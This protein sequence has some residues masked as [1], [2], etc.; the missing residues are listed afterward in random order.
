MRRAADLQLDELMRLSD[1]IGVLYRGR[2]TMS[3][4]P[5]AGVEEIGRM[6]LG[7]EAGR[8]EGR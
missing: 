4:F 5:R 8:E 6:M 1:R 7:V 3:D 2:L